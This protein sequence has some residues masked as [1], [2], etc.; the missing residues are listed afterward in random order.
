M[1][2]HLFSH[3]DRNLVRKG[4][5]VVKYITPIGTIGDGN[6]KTSS[7]NMYAHL[8]FSI[9]EGLSE[10]ELIAYISGWS[11]EKVK[12][13]YIEP[14]DIDFTK[15][16][17]T[18]MDVGSFGYGW[19]DWVGYGWHPGVDVNGLR[20][21][22]TDF[23]MPFKSSCNGTVVY[24]WRG[25]TSN[26]G[27]GNII[28]IAEEDGS[29]EP[30]LDFGVDVSHYQGDINWEKVK[31]AGVS[32][33]ICKCTEST[34]Y[35]DKTYDENKLEIKQRGIKFGAY[36]FARAGDVKKEADWFIKNVGSVNANDILVLDWEVNYKDPVG[37][38][39][40]FLDRVEEKTGVIP[41]I[42]TN[43]ARVKQF[44]F[45]K[46]AT[47]N[48]L[49]VA[50]YGKNSGKPEKEPSTGA[51]SKY[52]IWQYSSNGRVDGINGK[53]DVNKWNK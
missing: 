25:W 17:G 14:K 8:H 18:K 29:V 46:I 20:G 2:Y 51:W 31:N 41:F 32:F 35:K 4:D 21:G 52:S 9:S 10:S 5:K 3:M 38:C 44:N 16:F 53:V 43:E 23:G 34:S 50:K 1:R 48:P 39:K 42:Y 37:W 26:R 24:E 7:N 15:M 19:L 6:S 13:Y 12:K 27:W 11:K 36:H 28:I 40:E 33:A 49:W 47:K 30:L 22:N 45:A